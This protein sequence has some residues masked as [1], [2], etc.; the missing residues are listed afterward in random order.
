MTIMFCLSLR[1]MKITAYQ[2]MPKER[3]FECYFTTKVTLHSQRTHLTELLLEN[4]KHWVKFCPQMSPCNFNWFLCPKSSAILHS[5]KK[6]L[7]SKKLFNMAVHQQTHPEDVWFS[8]RGKEE[9][10]HTC[11]VQ[12][13]WIVLGCTLN[14]S[15]AAGTWGLLLA[16]LHT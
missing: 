3:S 9:E 14:L 15:L 10:I 16:L 13:P 11:S 4:Q 12:F 1:E 6:P 7:H 2:I 8:P 5:S